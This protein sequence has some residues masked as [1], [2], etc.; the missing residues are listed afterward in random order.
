M[1]SESIL[2]VDDNQDL[3]ENFVEAFELEG[4]EVMQAENGKVALELLMKLPEEKLPSCILLDLMMPVMDGFT[5]LNIL[6]RESF[7]HFKKIPIII[8]SANGGNL[9]ATPNAVA[10]LQKP[11]DL[12]VLYNMVN[13]FSRPDYEKA[14]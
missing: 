2:V 10:R 7:E 13:K 1:Y 12:D 11:V 14:V 4:Y 9:E 5:F 6:N 8:A 3:R